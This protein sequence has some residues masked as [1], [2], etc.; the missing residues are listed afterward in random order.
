VANGIEIQTLQRADR[1]LG[2][3]ACALL[4]PLRCLREREP[5]R[6]A[7]RVLAVKFW[8]IGSVQLLTPAVA[9]LRA[10]HPRAEIALLTLASNRDFAERL[11]V[12]DRV[13]TVDVERCGWTA[14]AR[15]VARLVRALRS[16][17]FDEVYDFEFFT[18]FSALVALATGA[19]RRHGFASTRVWRGAFH[20]DVVPF[21]RYYHLARNFRLLAGGENGVA[22]GAA[23]VASLPFDEHDEARAVAA[24]AR[25]G[26]DAETPLAVLNPNAGALSLERRWPAPRF[27]ELARRLIDERGWSVALVGTAGERE[28]AAEIAARVASRARAGRCANLAGELGI[29][30]LAALLARAQVFVTNDSGPMHVAAALGTPTLGLFG[31]ETPVMYAPLG[32]RARALYR[33]PPCSPCINVHR[34]KLARCVHGEALC[35]TSI[36]VDEVFAAALE[37]ARGGEPARRPEPALALSRS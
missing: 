9:A 37:L 24:L 15:R 31:P 8:G 19:P 2:L 25:S 12:F 29:A 36:S 6:P 27:A 7:R 33:P 22:V 4:Q 21:N 34:N 35:L 1:A 26:V 17:R 3:A 5:A 28:Y 30:D 16:E 32:R 23:D 18:R 13:V 10:R 11:A 20:T 14:L